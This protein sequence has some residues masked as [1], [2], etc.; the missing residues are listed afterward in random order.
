MR[1]V[2]PPDRSPPPRSMRKPAASVPA[3]TTAIVFSR[4]FRNCGRLPDAASNRCTS[5]DRPPPGCCDSR[6]RVLR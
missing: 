5:F 4:S 3:T 6:R 1:S 2:Q